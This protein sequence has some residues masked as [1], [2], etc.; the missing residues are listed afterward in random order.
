MSLFS[1]LSQH[2]GYEFVAQPLPGGT[3]ALDDRP[4]SLE[5]FVMMS[6]SGIRHVR[7]KLLGGQ[8]KWGDPVAPQDRKELNVRHPG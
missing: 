4:D 5:V 3:Q 2:N 6:R 8:G 1:S 7:S